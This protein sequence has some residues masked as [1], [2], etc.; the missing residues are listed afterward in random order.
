MLQFSTRC[1][2]CCVLLGLWFWK[3]FAGLGS[4]LSVWKRFLSKPDD[5]NLDT[6]NS[7]LS[8]IQW[9][10][11]VMRSLSPQD[12]K[13]RPE[14]PL[15]SCGPASWG[16]WKWDYNKFKRLMKNK[17]PTQFSR[18]GQQRTGEVK[19]VAWYLKIST[20]S[21]PERWLPGWEHWLYLKMTWL[22]FPAP[23]WWLTIFCNSSPTR[24][25]TLFW[26]PWALNACCTQTYMPTLIHNK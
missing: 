2:A 10:R 23:K 19:M 17:F 8:E 4:Y 3:P 16:E 1:R 14:K 13:Q 20:P 25:D 18:K 21:E 12:R 5:L 24:S 9:L 6:R 15:E 26:P 7:C 22:Q 11:C